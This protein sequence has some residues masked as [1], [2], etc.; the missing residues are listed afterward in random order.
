[1]LRLIL[2]VPLMAMLTLAGCAQNQAGTGTG[3]GSGQPQA[4]RTGTGA[5]IGAASGAVLGAVLGGDK[6]G[7]GA[8]IGAAAG[9]ALGAGVGR[10]MDQQQKEFE[11]VLA[12]EQAANEVEI[13]RVRED[14]LK[15]T[16]DSE[17]S[18]DFDSAM[19]K[20]SFEP[21]LEKL[22]EVLGKYEES[23]AV[24]VGHTDAVGSEDYNQR[25]SVRRAEAVETAL[26]DRG[27]AAARL[28]AQGR[29]EY[30]PRDTNDT[31]AGRQLNRRVEIFVTPTA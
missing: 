1:M 19:I 27:V 4:N 6:R 5:A 14:L 12:A 21:T 18:F 8:L 24:I 3:G 15:L 29:G 11:Q 31:E 7:R 30:E 26:I 2:V 28:D 22:A 13:E 20:P 25:L 10:A 9:G 16:L 17:V 23:D